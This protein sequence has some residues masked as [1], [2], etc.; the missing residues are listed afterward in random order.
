MSLKNKSDD[1]IIRID[2]NESAI[3]D[4]EKVTG[5]VIRLTPG[6]T[7]IPQEQKMGPILPGQSIKA[8]LSDDNALTGPLFKADKLKKATAKSDPFYLR[9]AF[10]ISTAAGTKRSCAIRCRFI[11]KKLRWPK[12]LT[13]AFKQRV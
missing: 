1:D 3:V 13:I 9:L 7:D 4:F 10:T 11:P 2:W 6:M 8:E 5:R 12:A